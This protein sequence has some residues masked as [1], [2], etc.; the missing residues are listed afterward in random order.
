MR[1]INIWENEAGQRLDRFLRKYL[2]KAPRGFI[3]KMIRK[4]NIK[5]NG[6]RAKPDTLIFEGDTIQLYLADSTIEKF[7]GDAEVVKS[8]LTP[9]IIYEDDNIILLN[10]P[11]G[12]LSHPAD[13][14]DGDNIVD[15]MIYYLYEKG[16]YDPKDEHTF[17]PSICNRL[18]RNTSGIIIGG[19]NYQSL[20]IINHAMRKGRIG[21]YYRTIVK[22]EVEEGRVI[23]GYLIK[24]EEANRVEIL[25]EEVEGSQKIITCINIL[26]I[27]QGYSFLEV[28]L[29]TGRT[30]QIR[31]HL[32]S[33]GHPIIGD[34]KYGDGNT[35]KYFKDRYGLNSQILHGYRV[36]FSGLERPLDYL[37]GREFVGL[38]DK[39]LIKIE[40]DFFN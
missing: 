4:K 20:R 12:I 3:Y 19:K 27:S 33:I 22:G 9:N 5:L 10:K 30:H 11:A 14:G 1:E 37:N 23:E 7:R 40:K 32:A 21:R 25:D 26:N 28:E 39:K 16:D 8:N 29:I 6:K 35:N 15:S 24:D 36:V 18:D 31:A 13:R 34:T 2:S 38:A 17:I